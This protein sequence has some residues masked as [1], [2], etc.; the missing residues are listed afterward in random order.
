MNIFSYSKQTITK[1]D[2]N[3]VIKTLKSNYLTQGPSVEKF[4]NKIKSFVKSKHAAAVNSAT[5]GLHL[6]CLSLGLKKND[7]LWTVPNSF[8]ASSN[9]ALYC[10]ASVEFVDINSNTWNIDE[11]LL[12]KKLLQTPSKKLPKILVVVHYAGEP[13]NLKKIFSLSKKFKFKI[14]EDASH[15]LGSKIC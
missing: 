8:V 11:N 5:S 1:N 12:E 6:A 7:Y 14:I 15:A 13:A 4:E 3:N 10:G 9:C 2:I